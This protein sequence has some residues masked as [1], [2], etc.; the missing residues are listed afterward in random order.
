M[1]YEVRVPIVGDGEPVRVAAIDWM[2][3]LVDLVRLFNAGSIAAADRGTELVAT[4][5]F[6]NEPVRDRFIDVLGPMLRSGLEAG[7]GTPALIIQQV[8]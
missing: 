1:I 7:D 5:T 4:I 8:G 6:V 2:L 3:R